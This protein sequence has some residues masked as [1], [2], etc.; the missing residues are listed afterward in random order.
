MTLGEGERKEEKDPG[1]A[2]DE[3]RLLAMQVSRPEKPEK[4]EKTLSCYTICQECLEVVDELFSGNALI[5]YRL[6]SL[7][8]YDARGSTIWA[9]KLDKRFGGLVFLVVAGIL[10]I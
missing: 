7:M 4:E 1:F 9:K 6:K 5:T 3:A 10:L 2:S 8:K